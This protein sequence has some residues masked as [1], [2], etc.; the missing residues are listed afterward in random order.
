MGYGQKGPRVTPAEPFKLRLGFLFI[1]ISDSLVQKSGIF[2]LL[3]MPPPLSLS[4]T[5]T[6][7]HTH[8]HMCLHTQAHTCTQIHVSY[9]LQ[10]LHCGRKVEYNLNFIHFLKNDFY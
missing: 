7:T 1:L 3:E 9:S 4:L 8:T 2:V 5:H 10:I 6:H